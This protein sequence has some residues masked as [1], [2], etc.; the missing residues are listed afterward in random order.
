[1]KIPDFQ[2]KLYRPSWVQ[3]NLPAVGENAAKVK[4]LV[5]PAKLLAVVKADAY[6]LGAV[7]VARVLA[8]SGVDKLGV[9]TLDEAVELRRAGIKTPILNM[10]A[11]FPCQAEVVVANN[12]E[13]MVYR[14]QVIEAISKAAQ[15]AKVKALLHLKIDTGMSRFGVSPDGAIALL[16]RMLSLPNIYFTGA[17]SHFAMSDSPD[18]SFALLQLSR[19]LKVREQIT[20]A[21]I[22]I[23]NYHICNSGGTLDLTEARL[24]MVRVGLLIYGFWPSPT[25]NRPFNI[26]P[27]IQVK[28]TIVSER[29]IKPG[30]TVGYGRRYTA[31]RD[32][33]IGVCPMGYSDGYDRKLRN[34]GQVL[35][36]GHRLPIIGGLCMDAFFIKLTDHPDVQTGDVVTVMGD[37]GDEAISPHDIAAWT[38][39]VSYEVISTFGRRLPRVYIRDGQVVGV[40]NPLLGIRG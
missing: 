40:V 28:T 10:G 4:A 25:V 18:K 30:D 23:N 27:A 16:H 29:W 31:E 33:R 2:N 36:N 13:Q 32:E 6:G 22:H 21:G 26:R 11:I 1:M 24:D 17:M 7:P 20:R 8:E 3:V 14:P 5:S 35:C 39:T 15:L 37:D 19:F 38:D 9:V 12:I 34:S